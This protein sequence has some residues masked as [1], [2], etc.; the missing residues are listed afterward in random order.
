[1]S[2]SEIVL[3]DLRCEVVPLCQCCEWDCQC[4][5]RFHA[6]L[7]M[8]PQSVLLIDLDTLYVSAIYVSGDYS[9]NSIFNFRL[10]LKKDQLS[11][12]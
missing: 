4:Q 6:V 7:Q 12:H 2:P 5:R 10:R 3:K 9:A 8:Q 11:A 1:M